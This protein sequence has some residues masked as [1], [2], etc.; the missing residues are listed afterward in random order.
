MVN[1]NSILGTDRKMLRK[2]EAP[3]SVTCRKGTLPL[4]IPP[5]H[6]GHLYS[7]GDE[8]LHQPDAMGRFKRNQ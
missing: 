5:C 1:L 4:L 2:Q 6:P 7:D 8:G 3:H